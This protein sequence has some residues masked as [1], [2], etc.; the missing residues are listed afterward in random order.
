M[1][2]LI[3]SGAELSVVAPSPQKHFHPNPGYVLTTAN[4]SSTQTFGQKL[5]TFDFG[6]L[7]TFRWNFT[8]ADIS[9]PIIGA[10]FLTHF[11]LLVDLKNRR[12]SD[13]CTRTQVNC[14]CRPAKTISHLTSLQPSTGPYQE[15]LN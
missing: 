13:Y 11:S 9:K 10:D 14:I 4:N 3:D 6:L 7:K 5:V 15:L 2:Y 12:F 1:Q 8:V